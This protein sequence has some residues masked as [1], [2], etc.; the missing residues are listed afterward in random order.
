[1]TQA[2][3]PE[4]LTGGQQPDDGGSER[5]S[6][7]AVAS[8]MAWLA[9]WIRHAPAERAPL[10]GIPAVWAIAQ[11]MHVAGVSP[12]FTG[13]ATVAAAGCAGWIGERRQH[14]RPVG[15]EMPGQEDG[16]QTG[17]EDLAG[18]DGAPG[19][20]TLPRAWQQ[21]YPRLRGAEL[22]VATA[23]VG[24]WATMAARWGALGGPHHLVGIIYASGAIGG[25]GWLR[26]HEAV[27]AARARRD[28]R[29]QAEAEAAARAA[30]WLH[31][32]MDWMA[33]AQQVDL[34]GS[35][36]MAIGPSRNGEQWVIDTYETRQLAAH[37]GNSTLASKLAGARRLRKHMVEAWP[38]P[39]WPYR[40]H[41][42]WRARDPWSG[43][44]ADGLIWHP[45]HTGQYDPGLPFAELVPPGRTIKKPVVFGADPESGTPLQVPLWDVQGAKRIAI[46]G[47]SGSG[48]SML[49]DTLREWITAC[50]DARL[51]QINLAKATEESWW[52]G[53]AAAAALAGTPDA[54]ARA[55][56]ILDFAFGS[57]K[58]R[59][60]HSPA[61]AAGARVVVPSAGEPLFVLMIDECD[62][63]AADPQRK[64]LLEEVASK[65]RSVGWA[66]IL[67][68]Q[69]GVQGW[70][71]P[72]V[73][74]NL[75]HLIFG[76]A[77]Q[78]DVRRLAGSD[79]FTLPDIS[80]YGRG[81]AGIFG[82][83]EHPTFEGMPCLRGR[84]FFWGEQSPGLLRLIRA[85]AAAQRPY[86][87]EPSLAPLAELW[88]SITGGKLVAASD[89]RYDVVATADG[90][91]APGVAGVRARIARIR[92][93]MSD[94]G[95][96]RAGGDAGTGQDDGDLPAPRSLPEA[97]QQRLRELLARPQGVTSR[98]AAALLPW[99]HTTINQQL[100]AWRAQGI[101][102]IRGEGSTRR[103]YATGLRVVPDPGHASPQTAVSCDARE[104]GQASGPS[105]LTPDEY[106][107]VMMIATWGLRDGPEQAIEQ[108]RAAGDSQ[109]L[110]TRAISLLADDRARVED[111]ARRAHVAAGAPLP[112]W[113]TPNDEEEGEGLEPGDLDDDG[114]EVVTGEPGSPWDDAILHVAA[115]A[116]EH[117][118]EAAMRLALDR[119]LSGDQTTQAL[120]LAQE[121]PDY[122]RQWREEQL[123]QA[124]GQHESVIP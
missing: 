100:A 94:G 63:V 102:E 108:A 83:C 48:K 25:Y 19:P 5:A 42:L 9:G 95:Q 96:P 70:I 13:A 90:R 124:A 62:V 91:T 81:N 55:L 41:I 111:V 17:G 87:L 18:D 71:P 21:P 66:L 49:A 33:L 32:R 46:M 59:G 122:V 11:I 28:A 85:R 26:T 61:L 51:V 118:G 38:D 54:D 43:G 45:W 80:S 76:K 7:S 104:P 30:E 97:D 8:L 20:A 101:A 36:L 114:G 119:Q 47:L 107:V 112:S 31:K 74:A 22:A 84:A 120:D 57:A 56:A 16:S 79:G 86:V 103:W 105:E 4:Q 58:L 123:R 40:I 34:A 35:H 27:R 116:L 10:A 29:A 50:P 89:D 72:G 115:R 15:E 99:S 14:R 92:H 77:R 69:R 121:D 1:M 12:L 98:E 113:L 110:I 67:L 37:C 24:A 68:G 93:S 117:G 78:S 73:R 75:S 52:E 53:L 3:G 88:Q 23:G 65:C 106:D 64:R 44:G 60:R 109:E 6:E 39:E 2:T 82:V